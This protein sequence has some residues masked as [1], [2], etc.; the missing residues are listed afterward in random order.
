MIYSRRWCVCLLIIYIEEDKTFVL[1]FCC[2]CLRTIQRDSY[3]AVVDLSFLVSFSSFSSH[4]SL[5]TLF[6]LLSIR[7]VQT[8]QLFYQRPCG[9]KTQEN[10]RQSGSEKMH[11]SWYEI[12][13][14][15]SYLSGTVNMRNERASCNNNLPFFHFLF[16]GYLLPFCFTSQMGQM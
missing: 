2:C 5:E 14:K 3:T 4:F 8:K 16:H 12:V 10:V 6:C 11:F 15:V 1:F 7:P 13:S 9:F